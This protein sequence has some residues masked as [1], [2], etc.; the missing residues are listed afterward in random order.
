[1]C[2]HI[3]TYHAV[4]HDSM[5]QKTKDPFDHLLYYF[6]L[7]RPDAVFFKKALH[8]SCVYLAYSNSADMLNGVQIENS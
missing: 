4:H 8:L 3:S 2:A 6:F 7:F 1:M 5:S